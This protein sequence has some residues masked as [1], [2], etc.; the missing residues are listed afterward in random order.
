M[1]GAVYGIEALSFRLSASRLFDHSP[2][3]IPLAIAVMLWT[4]ALFGTFGT[5]TFIYFQF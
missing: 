3:L 5:Q 1:I 2:W 4:I